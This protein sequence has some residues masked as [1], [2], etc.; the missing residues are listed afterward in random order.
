MRITYIHVCNS[1]NDTNLYKI[2]WHIIKK[3]K[4]EILNNSIINDNRNTCSTNE[5]STMK[6]G[7]STEE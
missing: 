2:S 5:D 4:I 1:Y 7:E 3:L 6:K